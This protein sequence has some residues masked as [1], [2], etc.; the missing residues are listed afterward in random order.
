M[1]DENNSKQIVKYFAD[2]F[3]DEEVLYLFRKHPVVM[4]KGL[5]FGLFGPVVGVLPSAINPSLGMG[6][7]FDGLIAGAV[8][9]LIIFIPSWVGWYF[10]VFILTN[11]RFIQIK[12]KG[13]FTRSV[14]DLGLKQIQSVSYEIAGIQETLLGFG[15]IIMKTYVGDVIIH[16]I[17]HPAKVQ[18]KI[19][20]LLR[21][22]GVSATYMP[23][24]SSREY[25]SEETEEV[26]EA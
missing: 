12:Q 2:Q 17:H 24:A 5:I 23:V 13:F 19:V 14:S 21:D 4:R 15:T 11:Q 22:L 9:G 8:L 16:D 20:G 3:D 7:F 6:A 26:E 1:E 10:S 25:M 18:K